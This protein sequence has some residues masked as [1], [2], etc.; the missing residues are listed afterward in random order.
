MWCTCEIKKIWIALLCNGCK[1]VSRFMIIKTKSINCIMCSH[2]HFGVEKWQHR[3]NR[4][5]EGKIINMRYKNTML[6]SLMHKMSLKD[7]CMNVTV[8][9]GS[10]SFFT[11]T[12]CMYPNLTPSWIY[13]HTWLQIQKL[14]HNSTRN[15]TD[16]CILV[17]RRYNV[18]FC[19]WLFWHRKEPLIIIMIFPFSTNNIHLQRIWK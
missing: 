13:L 4:F 14:I 10:N 3:N 17:Y 16:T 7:G 8:P 18:S 2:C 12:L 15:F 19:N 6:M 5:L 9:A 1:L 11:F